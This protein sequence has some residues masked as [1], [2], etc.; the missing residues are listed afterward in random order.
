MKHIFIMAAIIYLSACSGETQSQVEDKPVPTPSVEAPAEAEPDAPDALSGATS[1]VSETLLNGIFIVPPQNHATVTLTMG[2]IIKST[3]LIEGRYVNKGEVLAVIDNPEFIELQQN[4]LES[5]AK[6]EYLEKEYIRQ[7]NLLSQ[8]AASEKRFQQSK[9]EY[10]STKTMA[11]AMSARLS[12]L[13]IE[14]NR[15]MEEGLMTR[16]EVKASLSGYITNADVNVGKYMNPG[17]PVCEIIDKNNL[18]LQLT[19]YEKDLS[20]LKVGKSVEF[21]VNGME[22][23]NFEA[24]I[25][26]IDQT[27]DRENRSVKVFANLKNSSSMF[28]PGMYV[29]AR[30]KEN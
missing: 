26:S 7:Q 16:L 13:G 8:E 5:V 20:S 9:S 10:L 29:S 6:L 4:Y 27:V 14:A 25:V 23:Q 1:H 22:K 19:A 15:L 12:L 3:S 28:F 18:M 21:S 24:E 30:I 11:E 2:G 17:E